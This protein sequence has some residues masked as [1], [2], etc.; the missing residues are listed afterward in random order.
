[1]DLIDEF[2]LTEMLNFHFRLKNAVTAKIRNLPG[3][4]YLEDAAEK[5]LMNFRLV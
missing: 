3:R 2:T 5:P 4:M 1:M